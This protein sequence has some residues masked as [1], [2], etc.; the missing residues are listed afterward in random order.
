MNGP[1]TKSNGNFKI[2]LCTATG[3]TA[4]RWALQIEIDFGAHDFSVNELKVVNISSPI[5]GPLH[6]LTPHIAAGALHDSKERCD[7]PKCLPE[8]RVAVQDE[9]YSWIV[10]GDPDSE[11]VD[12]KWVTG[13]PGTGKSAIM[14]SLTEMCKEKGVLVVTFFF[15]ASASPQCRTKTAFIPTLAYQLAQNLPEFKDQAA[16]SLQSDPLLFKKTLRSQMEALILTPLRRVAPIIQPGLVLVDGLDECEAEA[17]FPSPTS[18]SSKERTKD[19]D[20]LEILQVLQEASLDP[21]FPFRIVVASRPERVFRQ[22]FQESSFPPSVVLDEKYDP[23]ADIALFLRAKFSE[24]RRQYNISPSWPSPGT[25]AIILNQ[26]S[27][28]FNYAATLIRYITTSRQ[29]SPC[30]LLDQVLGAKGTSGATNLLSHLDAV[31]THILRSSPDPALAVKWLWTIMGRSPNGYGLLLFS[32][33]MDFYSAS[34]I[35]MFLQANDGDAEYILGN[36][37]SLIHIPPPND[38]ESSYRPH[39]KSLMDFLPCKVFG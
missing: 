6:E 2:P 22:F 33:P 32:Q 36:L 34:F 20:Q 8:T 28:Q 37:H 11:M 25:L 10:H 23:N 12:I 9:L 1:Q 14:G 5:A 16:H 35:N 17:Y 21:A 39:H 4:F 7:A 26:A 3:G 29:G 27:G 13:P 19:Q 24:I 18:S 30:V 38:L 31:Y 15:S